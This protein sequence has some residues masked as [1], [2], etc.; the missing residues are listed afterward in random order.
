M[1]V[2]TI[3]SLGL[4]VCGNTSHAPGNIP[5]WPGILPP[6]AG[7]F[8]MTVILP[9]APTV[10]LPSGGN[11]TAPVGN[12]TG[13]AGIF[14][15]GLVIFQAGGDIPGL[16]RRDSRPARGCSRGWGGYSP[17]PCGRGVPRGKKCPQSSC[18]LF[19]F[20]IYIRL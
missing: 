7:N 19:L 16:W 17:P 11:I 12:A 6:E 2:P 5:G 10:I 20:R 15:A 13:W 14:P 8:T 9:P 18:F 4:P 1:V 3:P